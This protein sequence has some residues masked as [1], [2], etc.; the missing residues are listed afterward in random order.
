[1]WLTAELEVVDVYW[2]VNEE[3]AFT[4]NKY[5]YADE[6]VLSAYDSGMSSHTEKK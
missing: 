1:M 3:M 4:D 6:D 2:N 5:W